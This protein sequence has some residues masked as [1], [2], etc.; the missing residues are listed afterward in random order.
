MTK[1]NWEPELD[2]SPQLDEEGRKLFRHVPGLGG[3][4]I[5]IL[6]LRKRK[7]TLNI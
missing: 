5:V 7:R 1:D 3:P 6:V 2:D 4:K